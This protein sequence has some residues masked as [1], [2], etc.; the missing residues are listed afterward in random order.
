MNLFDHSDSR[1]VASTI[2][3]LTTLQA[4]AYSG[5]IRG[6]TGHK[7]P[8]V[9]A[10]A[11][12]YL[13]QCE[14]L[15]I[16][17]VEKM[18]HTRGASYKLSALYVIRVIDDG[19][20][21]DLVQ[22][23]LTDPDPDVRA[24]ALDHVESR[25]EKDENANDLLEMVLAGNIRIRS[26]DSSHNPPSPGKR[27]VA[28]ALDLTVWTAITALIVA[29]Q[30]R[31]INTDT[32]LPSVAVV[33]VAGVLFLIRDGLRQGR[34]LGKGLMG[35]RVVRTS[36]GQCIS[37]LTA[38][39]RQV[40]LCVP[41]LNL[42]ELAYIYS[43]AQGLRVADR[44][45]GSSVIDE[46]ELNVPV[47]GYLVVPLIYVCLAA[48]T[49]FGVTKGADVAERYLSP[50]GFT[51][52]LSPGW[53]F[54]TKGETKVIATRKSFIYGHEVL[55]TISVIPLRLMQM[56]EPG[57]SLEQ[58]LQRQG[59]GF[60]LNKIVEFKAKG[61]LG[62]PELKVMDDEPMGSG[63]AYG[64]EICFGPP[65]HRRVFHGYLVPQ[66]PYLYFMSPLYLGADALSRR[67]KES[68]EIMRKVVNR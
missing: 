54:V 11:L 63:P 24:A 64:F 35:L 19:S 28:G 36:S 13:H 60:C 23:A 57:R 48:T 33:I 34:G 22:H 7:S 52:A 9:W 17:Q 55:L 21:L 46:E 30:I 3:A 59:Q 40:L 1:V 32:L 14:E 31:L 56:A 18:L 61:V 62:K 65:A 41:F 53:S 2:E 4:S 20:L 26:D 47:P 29:V 37:P 58:L 25:A 68:L 8:R 39:L 27:M 12:I 67:K 10:N 51:V 45:L 16:E 49:Y 38:F 66:G 15:D 50:K 42:V 5:R 44:W 43:D 6:F